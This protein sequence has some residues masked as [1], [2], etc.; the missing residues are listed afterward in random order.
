[1][2]KSITCITLAAIACSISGSA[3]AQ[4]K[5]EDVIKFRKSV[6]TIQAWHM[7]PMAAM[8]KE[9]RPY[10]Q[11]AFAYNA[12]VI[13]LTARM[14][15]EAF[16]PGTDKAADVETRAKPEIWTEP[17]KFK[18]A[19]DRFQAEASKLVVASKAGSLD[20]VRPVFGA[21]AKA[22]GACHDAFRTK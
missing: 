2:K 14:K 10:D 12:Q 1:M 8:V 17:E 18:Q 15:G 4:A 5:P 11:D 20:A 9:Q 22:C 6:M 19:L 7:R 21:V 16:A 3:L 13:G